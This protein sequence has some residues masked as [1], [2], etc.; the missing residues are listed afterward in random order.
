MKRSVILLGLLISFTIATGALARSLVEGE[1]YV[2][3]VRYQPDVVLRMKRH[4]VSGLK[5]LQPDTLFTDDFESGPGNWIGDWGLTG[6]QA[7][8]PDSSF[9]DSPDTLSP[10]DTVLFSYMASGVDLSG[11]MGATLVFWKLHWLEEG[12]DYGYLE[13]STDG[14]SNWIVLKSYNDTLDVWTPDTTDLGGFCGNAD[15]RVGFRVVTDPNYTEEGWF[16]D[17]VLI[18]GSMEDYTPPL[19]LHVPPADTESVPDTLIVV[20]QITDM[21]GVV[22]D[23]LYYRF[24]GG[25]YT[26]VTHDS[27]SGD[28]FYFTIPGSPAGTFVDYYLAA[29]DGAVPPNR[30]E[31]EL[32]GYVAGTVIYYDDGEEEFVYGYAAGYKLA[33]R[34]T[35]GA[36]SALVATAVYRFYMDTTHPL[37]SVWIHLWN[38]LGGIPGTDLIPRF[39]IWP[40]NTP[41]D[42]LAWTKVDLRSYQ[43]VVPAADFHAGCEWLS[44]YPYLSGDDPPIAGRTMLD[45][46]T[47]WFLASNDAYVRV[48]V[49]LNPVG[50]EETPSLDSAPDRDAVLMQNRPN[51]FGAGGTT[52]SFNVKRSTSHVSLSVYDLSGRLVR[53]LVDESR[54]PGHHAVSWDGRNDM[55]EE[56]ASGIY[57]CRLTATNHGGSA[58]GGVTGGFTSTKSMVVLR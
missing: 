41:Q 2:A 49:G 22:S 38:D 19:I 23:S 42:P 20:T 25:P 37:D 55:G 12:F 33:V 56:V 36:D 32:Y 48:V 40:V 6:E 26:E 18:T 16:V 44:T 31:T 47:G 45:A 50:V 27:V 35:H 7:H 24:D 46:G 11:Y 9:T 57:F 58:S 51:P 1:G 4:E 53:T 30:G 34:M 21:S 43:L 54:E 15:V 10:S 28:T 52:I 3:G 14:G 39:K 8:S 17:D 13:V 5:L 29:T